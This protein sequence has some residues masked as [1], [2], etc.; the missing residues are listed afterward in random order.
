MKHRLIE[1]LVGLMFGLGLLMSGMS[2]PSKVLG[3]L[4]IFGLWDP[5]LLLVMG[6]AV[7]VGLFAFHFAKKRSKNL[8]GGKLHIPLSKQID[9]PLIVG[10]ILFGIGWGLAGFC[11]GPAIISFAQGQEKSMVFVFSMIAGMILFEILNRR[12]QK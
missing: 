10:A 11:P 3:F 5:S 7:F 9:F 12:R 4:D 8:L 2:N 6:G 1:F